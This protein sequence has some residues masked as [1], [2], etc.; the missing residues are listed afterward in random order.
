MKKTTK[1]IYSSIITMIVVFVFSGHYAHAALLSLSGDKEKITIGE[2]TRID[3]FINSENEQINTIAGTL[4]IDPSLVNVDSVMIGNSIVPFWVEQPALTSSSDTI[5]FSGVIP[6]GITTEKG[7]LFSVV[8]TA[9]KTGEIPISIISPTVLL[10]DGN[11]TDVPTATKNI[12]V[13]VVADG[14]SKQQSYE[15]SDTLPPEKFEIVRTKDSSLFDNTW[16]IV[17]ATQD[18]GSGIGHYEICEAFFSKCVQEKSPFQLSHQSNWYFITVRAFDNQNNMQAA[19]LVSKNI[20]IT[21]ASVIILGILIMIYVFF[22]KK[23]RK[24]FGV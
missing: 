8:M 19:F 12:T 16:F 5:V 1:Q 11:G 3:V 10:N 13:S 6:G 22:I 14:I 23:R 17:F 15:I 18:K 24:L 9:K 7:Y 4:N 2:S 20:K 21:F